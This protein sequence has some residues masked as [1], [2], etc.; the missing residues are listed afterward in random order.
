MEVK[1]NNNCLNNIDHVIVE[2]NEKYFG[3]SGLENIHKYLLE[4]G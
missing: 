3:F 4:I 1:S 2:V